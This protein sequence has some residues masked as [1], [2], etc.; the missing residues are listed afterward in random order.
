MLVVPCSFYKRVDK[1]LVMKKDSNNSGKQEAMAQNGAATELDRIYN[2][3]DTTYA[4]ELFMRF[5]NNQL[6]KKGFEEYLDSLPPEG[7]I[8]RIKLEQ[9]LDGQNTDVDV[10]LSTR[11]GQLVWTAG[12]GHVFKT[13]PPN[14]VRSHPIWKTLTKTPQMAASLSASARYIDLSMTNRSATMA[15][16]TPGSWFWFSPDDNHINIDLFHTLLC[17][18]GKDLAPGLK[19]LAHAI[20]INMHEVGHSQLSL[21]FTDKMME[22]REKEVALLEESKE[23]KLT[24]EEYKQLVRIRTEFKLRMNIWNAAEDNCVNRYAVNKSR[25]FPHDFKTSQNQVNMLLQGTGYYLKNQDFKNADKNYVREVMEKIEDKLKS[26]ERK[27]VREAGLAINKLS[28]A[29]MM[30]FYVTNGL[31]EVDDVKTWKKIGVDPENIKMSGSEDDGTASDLKDFETLMEMNI[32]P[33]GVANLQPSGRDRWLLRSTFNRKVHDYSDRRCELIEE[34]WD[35][36][37]AQHAEILIDAAEKNAEDRM[38]Q[39]KKENDDNK[40]EQGQDGQQD[41]NSSG[42]GEPGQGQGEGDSDDPNPG[43]GDGTGQDGDGQGAGESPSQ[44][45]EGAEGGKGQSGEGEGQGNPK[46]D[47]SSSQSDGGG[48]GQPDK[49]E[50]GEG[51]GQGQGQPGGNDDPGPGGGPGTVDVDGVGDMPVDDALPANP[52]DAR[53]DARKGSE[54]ETKP[55]DAKTIR[56]LNKEAKENEKKAEEAE[57]AKKE[58]QE[59]AKNKNNDGDGKG[60]DGK[61][62]GDGEPSDD[63]DQDGKPSDLDM[64]SK[65][66]KGGRESGMDLKKLSQ[67]D[68]RHFR[69]RI[70]ELE[71]LVARA[72]KDLIYIRNQQ[73]QIVRGLSREKEEL[74]R[75][76]EL[77]ERL[78]MRSHMNYAVKRATGQRI[79][80]DDKK[81]WR[82]DQIQ[83]EPTS[84]ELWILGDGS[85]SM[86]G[87]LAGGGR[88]I[89]SAVQ[90]MA[91]L[92]EASQ[93]AD[94]DAFVGMWGDSYIRLL[95]KPGLTYQ[96]I[97]DN[98]QRV[99]DGINSGTVLTPAFTEAVDIS[100]K[101]DLDS[102]GRVKRFAGMTHFLI[103]SDGE[104]S[105]S[106]IRPL[107]KMINNLFRYGPKVSID[108]AVL[109]GDGRGGTQMERVIELVKQ[110]NPAAPIEIISSNRAQEIPVML[111]RQIKR[112]FEQSAKNMK[113]VPDRDKREAFTRAHRAIKK[114]G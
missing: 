68:W 31:F 89:D 87:T 24:Q 78:D 27:K 44:G 37:A 88:R 111:T 100:S 71:P 77:R 95:A 58:A 62:K 7:D 38:K 65:S 114:L 107:A 57:K 2:D 22:L 14:T 39:K 80:K 74:P 70:N 3:P 53:K 75:E 26:E 18:F 36:Y 69:K 91:V 59:S 15:W 1:G 21:R 45:V 108:I 76:G 47:P 46:D 16:G 42:E 32:G 10:D 13:S 110:K 23:R 85:G 12:L 40:Q 92:Y 81:R 25:E 11:A 6:D 30:S 82:K 112:R 79:E 109:A 101:Q 97:G 90:S 5:R 9:L 55:E 43:D 105:H 99:R 72:A 83:T 17:G 60:K 51:Q 94:I 103:L 20:G 67:G 84:V 102:K 50:P 19:G 33:Q 35:K 61:G 63:E 28:Q 4:L 34:I 93:R 64:N 73:K 54:E 113:A 8:E 106:D 96:Q 41:E 48:S 52:E 66:S 49:G 56:D 98:F 104:L 29:I 86:N